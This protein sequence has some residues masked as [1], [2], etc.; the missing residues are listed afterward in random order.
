MLILARIVF[1][2]STADSAQAS[3]KRKQ[4]KRQRLEKQTIRAKSVLGQIIRLPLVYLELN[5]KQFVYV[6]HTSFSAS[7]VL[8][9]N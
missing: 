4:V 1:G 5:D 7:K 8:K 2:V 9:E 6:K 3:S